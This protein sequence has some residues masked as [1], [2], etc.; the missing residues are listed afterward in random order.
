MLKAAAVALAVAMP[1]AAGA[2][3]LVN[4]TG[5]D[6]AAN[7]GGVPTGVSAYQLVGNLIRYALGLVGALF[8]ILIIRGGLQWMTSGGDQ[9][10]LKGAKQLI[11]NSS[12]GLAVVLVAYAITTFVVNTITQASL[13]RPQ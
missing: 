12:I 9:E 4:E 7:Y 2:L 13:A 11:T 10:K 5:L 8:L 6:A 1:I 3:N